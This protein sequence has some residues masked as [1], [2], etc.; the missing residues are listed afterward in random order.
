M[1]WT[2]LGDELGGEARDLTD[3]EFRTHIEALLWSNQRLLDLYVPRRDLRRFAETADPA[4]AAAGLVA[5]GWWQPA[6]DGWYVG[7]RFPE[8]QLERTVVEYRKDSAALRKRRQRMHAA[9]D[10]SICLSANCADVTRDG[11]RDPGRV[12]SGTGKAV[13][14]KPNSTP[15][16]DPSPRPAKAA[17][18][19][20]SNGQI[21]AAPP[22]TGD[23][24][25]P[26]VHRE[27]RKPAGVLPVASVTAVTR[28]RRPDETDL[29]YRRRMQWMNR[30]AAKAAS[31]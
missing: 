9:A 11:T 14:A 23:A 10:H 3:A 16:P 25:K 7:V 20:S 26:V 15:K 17:D 21:Q 19:P 30:Q 28:A 2:K 8:W 18:R 4:A 6:G 29:D 1:T 27:R 5:K 24:P 12:G 13:R 22:K 31:R